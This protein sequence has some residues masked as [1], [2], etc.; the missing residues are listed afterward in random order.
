[1]PRTCTIC[2]HKRRADIDKALVDRR[3]FRDIARQF[4]VGPDSLWRHSD[5]HLPAKLVRAKRAA[6]AVEADAL[7]DQVLDLRDKALGVLDSAEGEGD[8][9]GSIAAIR[10]ARACIELLGKLAGQLA[11]APT[12]NITLSAEWMTVQATVLAALQP[13]PEAR[14]AVA[15]AL[16]HHEASHA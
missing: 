10:E 12:I 1:M 4:D 7:L 9:Q 6:E 3:P 8:R 5:D 15:A 14:I 2:T 16:E 11:S 13:H